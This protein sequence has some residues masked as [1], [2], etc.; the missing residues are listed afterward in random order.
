MERRTFISG[1]TTVAL[2]AARLTTEAQQAKRLPIVGYLGTA[3]ARGDNEYF[4]AFLQGLREVG[5]IE[6]EGMLIEYRSAEGK[7]E[8][9]PGLVAELLALKPDV[10]L[11]A[12]PYAI[13]A[14]SEQ[15]PRCPSWDS[16][17]RA[18]GS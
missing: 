17:S 3:Q 4:H 7:P 6:G 1:L 13:K 18:T 5:R 11:A 15:R 9:L 10:L 12:N 8:R 2:V 14:I 16:T